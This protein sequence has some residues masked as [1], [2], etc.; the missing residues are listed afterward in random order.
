MDSLQS[1][2]FSELYRVFIAQ[3]AR[4]FVVTGV[5]SLLFMLK[6][7]CHFMIAKFPEEREAIQELFKILATK[8]K[9]DV[10]HTRVSLP[11]FRLLPRT[12]THLSVRVCILPIIYIR[13]LL[14]T[15]L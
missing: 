5:S 12:L 13:V 1:Y 15:V 6:Q 7:S 9:R 11:N 14:A 8:G 2:I 10:R 4:Q 3:M